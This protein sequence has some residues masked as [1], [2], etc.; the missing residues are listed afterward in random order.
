MVTLSNKDCSEVVMEQPVN[1]IINGDS[2]S[3][4]HKLPDAF[5]DVGVT[6]P[7]YN[8]LEKHNGGLVKKWFMINTKTA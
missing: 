6:S 4:L 7:P 2:L 1:T 5:I 3:E 8:K